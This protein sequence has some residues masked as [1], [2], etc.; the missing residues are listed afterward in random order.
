VV[1]EVLHE[2]AEH[3]GSL[4][5]AEE[6]C[7]LAWLVIK[8]ACLE[9]L[10]TGVLAFLRDLF[11]RN[12]KVD[13]VAD[14]VTS[15]DTSLGLPVCLLNF[16]FFSFLLADLLHLLV[17]HRELCLNV[18]S[19]GVGALHPRVANDICHRKTLMC[20]ELEHAGN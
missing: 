13:L 7:V 12:V 8:L 19:T 4:I 10:N 6:L 17:A 18:S 2:L 11:S 20:V 16:I 9:D 14:S 5:S 15:A 1:L 3:V